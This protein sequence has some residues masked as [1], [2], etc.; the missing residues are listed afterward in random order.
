MEA[1]YFTI[2]YWFCHTSTW[3]HHRHTRVPHPEPPSCLPPRTI[4]LGHPNA[5]AP[6]ILYWDIILRLKIIF[7][8]DF[9]NILPISSA[10]QCYCWENVFLFQ[11]LCMLLGFLFVLF[12]LG[13]LVGS[14]QHLSTLKFHSNVSLSMFS[15]IYYILLAP[16]FWKLLSF[17]YGKFYFIVLLIT[18]CPVITF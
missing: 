17:I 5:L 16:S 6:R 12:P 2:L 11:S 8:L 3:I 18:S 7:V 14:S 10:I 13:K 15:F 9:E 4:P 1:N